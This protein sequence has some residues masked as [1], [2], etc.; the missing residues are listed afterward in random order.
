M[1]K[2]PY[3][4]SKTSKISKVLN[5]DQRR[6]TLS[7]IKSTAKLAESLALQGDDYKKE[8]QTLNLFKD[9]LKK[10]INI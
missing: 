10:Q 3:S 6:A 8:L 4:N 2:S 9:K 7:L 5:K 1:T